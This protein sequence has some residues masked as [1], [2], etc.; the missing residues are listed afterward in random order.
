MSAS[1]GPS[2]PHFGALESLRGI[3]ALCVVFYHI[4]WIN[5][6][7]GMNFF[8]NSYLMVDFFFVLSGFVI[9]HSYGSRIVSMESA[10]RFVF[11][12]LG[13]LYPL[14]LATLLVFL[15]IEISKYIAD[16]RYGLVAN[17]PAFSVNNGNSFFENL[18]MVHA[19]NLQDRPTWNGPSWSIS[20]EF[21]AY[22]SFLPVMLLFRGRRIAMSVF[23]LLLSLLCFTYLYRKVGHLDVFAQDSVIRCIA[24]FYLGI[25]VYQARTVYFLYLSGSDRS[26]GINLM[27]IAAFTGIAV[28]MSVASEHKMQFMQ[29]VLFSLVVF[30]VSLVPPDYGINVLLNR[31]PLRWLGMVSYSVYMVHQ[32][33]LWSVSQFMR[34]TLG[35]QETAG[36]LDPG[37]LTGNLLTFVSVALI[38]VTSHY[39][40]RFIEDRYR[41]KSRDLADRIWQAPAISEGSRVA[42]QDN[43]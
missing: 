15:G 42:G 32:I 14:H 1:E 4:D 20:A 5:S 12:R 28:L 21:F 29:P 26:S 30:S 34:V 27:S 9:Y 17:T 19:W 41:I 8:R 25:C 3:A 23:S 11:L 7:T 33:V 2:R 38:L 36:A 39:S 24:G 18:L 13:R 37:L 40:F 35:T 16:V 31:K 43:S 10:G 6:L 22:L